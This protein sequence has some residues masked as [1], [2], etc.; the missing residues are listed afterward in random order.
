MG[1]MELDRT[2][3]DELVV[4]FT[5]R[6][7]DADERRELLAEVGLED[8]SWAEVLPAAGDRLGPLATEASSRRPKDPMLGELA[9][10]LNPSSVP[11]KAAI[12]ALVGL[13][14][15]A[16]GAG[17]WYATADEH[18]ERRQPAPVE[19][20]PV[21][22]ASPVPVAVSEEPAPEAPAPEAPVAEAPVAEAPVAEEVAPEPAIVTVEAPEP[23]PLP[24]GPTNGRCGGPEGTIVGYWYAGFP[25]EAVVGEVYTLKFGK[26]VRA[27]YPR[28]ANGWSA[29]EAIRCALNSGDEVRVS[30]APV[31]VDGGKYWV[32][33]TAGDLLTP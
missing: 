13:L 8:A 24:I 14:V 25:F 27:D 30:Q 19:E 21:E 17:A 28:K 6:F 10:T 29:E 11:M 5:K 4:F 26:Y 7:P 9:A 16:L 31:L 12:G 15:M 23:E 2:D 3:I 33:L 18:I 20:A 22:V 32:P 1:R